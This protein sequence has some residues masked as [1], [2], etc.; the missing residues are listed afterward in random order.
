MDKGESSSASPPAPERDNPFKL[1]LLRILLES[2]RPLGVH[3]F[4]VE[5]RRHGLLEEIPLDDLQLFRVNF[6]LMN[7]LYCLQD[8]V[9][10]L[11]KRL[12]VS[13]LETCLVDEKPF[14][15]IAGEAEEPGL[16]IHSGDDALRAYYLDWGNLERTTA[17]DVASLLEG[18][19]QRYAGLTDSEDARATLGV[20]PTAGKD[21]IRRAYRRAVNRC[22][23]DKGGDARI[24]VKVRE[25]YE[26]LMLEC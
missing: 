10:E 11:G 3:E 1:P 13:A 8:E 9:G 5:L 23:P 20:G 15:A 24:F 21:E 26:A 17:A 6:L 4:T 19:W 25:A 18:F 12:H 16:A 2:D 14:S 22:H 7:A